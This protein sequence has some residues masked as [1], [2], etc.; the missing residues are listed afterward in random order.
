MI[1]LL[2]CYFKSRN[3][4]RVNLLKKFIDEK[5]QSMC[6]TPRLRLPRPTRPTVMFLSHAIAYLVTYLV[7][8]LVMFLLETASVQLVLSTIYFFIYFF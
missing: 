4:K 2:F 5:F 6:V 8:S 3:V 7:Y 1:E